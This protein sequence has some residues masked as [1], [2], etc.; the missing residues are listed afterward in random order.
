MGTGFWDVAAKPVEVRL[1]SL[2]SIPLSWQ[3]RLAAF[4]KGAIVREG[5]WRRTGNVL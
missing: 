5:R 2:H 4:S 1:F 3:S